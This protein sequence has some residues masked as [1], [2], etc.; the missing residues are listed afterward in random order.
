MKI[1][2]TIL[3]AGQLGLLQAQ[4]YIKPPTIGIHY[5]LTDFATAEKI[6]ATSLGDV[7]KNKQW[8]RPQQMMTG[9][10]ID[11]LKGITKN[12]DFAVSANYTS[13]ID[14]FNLPNTNITNYTLFT[15]DAVLNI[16]LLSDRYYVRPFIL[17]GAGLYMQNGTGGYAPLGAGVQ[18]NVFNAAIINAQLQ[19][20]LPF[21]NTD[22]PALFYQVGFAT[23]I[24]KKK[25]PPA[26]PAPVVPENQPEQK[27]VPQVIEIKPVFNNITVTVQDEETRQP[28]PY[29]EVAL[30]GA[31]GK[32][33]TATTGPDG[34]VVFTNIQAGGHTI[35]GSL[36]H[37]DATPVTLTSS[38]FDSS[39]NP[40]A[41]TLLHNDP[42]FTLVG[43]TVDK[44]ED[45][46]VGNTIITVTNSTQNSVIR[47]TSNETDGAFT[48]QLDA[49]S[50]FVIVG[51]KANY[52]SNIENVSTKGLNRSTTLYVKLELGIQEAKAGQAIVLNK[53]YFE[54]GKS[55]LNTASSSDLDRLVQFMKDNPSTRL[56]ILG[57]TDNVGSLANN[58]ALSLGRANSV[59]NYLVKNGIDKSRLS[60]RGLGPS[61]PVASNAT[62]EGRAQNR[63]VEMKVV[64]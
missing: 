44:T 9:F 63:R 12:I 36:N 33:L 8:S 45:K 5:A 29:A 4:H 43:H 15:A 56:E 28:L 46:P 57:Y 23:S 54:T 38:S 22:N 37:V 10:G 64:E 55:L 39:G 7:L 50:D 59:V 24:L 40:I 20:R 35:T 21:K 11:F 25:A 6:K 17:A 26:K 32:V 31:D 49:G 62:A 61:N 48:V 2:F 27:P 16:K 52:F 19:Y 14:A 51:K 3:A 60:A 53:I 30:T 41:A 58:N 34:K 13:G 1:L 47:A 18:F 42:R